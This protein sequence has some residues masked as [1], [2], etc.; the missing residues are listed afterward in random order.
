MVCKEEPV[1]GKWADEARGR[2]G[3]A[4]EDLALDLSDVEGLVGKV[5]GFLLYE[6]KED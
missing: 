2:D 1:L 5:R 4:L 3:L 6:F